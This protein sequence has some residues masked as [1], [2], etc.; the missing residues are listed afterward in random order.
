MQAMNEK[1]ISELRDMEA[2]LEANE[3]EVGQLR[4]K[5]AE[6]EV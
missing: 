4:K 6:V 2:S 5:L 1:L 3:H